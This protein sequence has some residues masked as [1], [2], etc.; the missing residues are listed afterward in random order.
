MAG[1]GKSTISRT[2]AQSLA[3]KEVL[4]ASF[5]FK[6]GEGDRG[7]TSRFFTTIAAQLA[8]ELP[9]LVP[10][11][12]AALEANPSL[13]EKSMEQQFNKLLLDPLSVIWQ[14]SLAARKKVIVLIDALDECEEE[15]HI[16]TILSLLSRFR[17]I[18]GIDLRIFVTSRPELPIRLG[19]KKIN[20]DAH[21]DVAL[22]DIPERIVDHDLRAVLASELDMLREEHSLHPPWPTRD[23]LD[24]LV[25]ITRP[26][27]IHA[28]TVCR[29]ISDELL[30][31]PRDLLKNILKFRGNSSTS[32]LSATYHPVLHQ[33]V[34][35][36]QNYSREMILRRFR[37]IVGTIIALFN[38][39]PK[40]ALVALLD[41]STSHV[42][43]VLNRLHSVLRVPSTE[44][45][46]IQLF[47]LSFHDFLVDCDQCDTDFWIDEEA[48]HSRIA[49]RCIQIMSAKEGLREDI[50]GL[51]HPGKLR[52]EVSS[53]TV[54]TC[55]PAVLQYACRHWVDHLQRSGRTIRD[56]EETDNFLRKHF[57]HF[58]E[59]LGLLGR[60]SESILMIATLQSLLSV[61]QNY[62]VIQFHYL[63]TSRTTG[64]HSVPYF[65]KML[66][67]FY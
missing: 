32:D 10:H 16:Q 50:C 55:L 43:G 39:L 64:A 33:L 6:R 11:I 37:L 5:F 63:T 29:Y 18:K 46:P 2:V 34:A 62:H 14:K 45:L 7:N 24:A 12:V 40:P 47:H 8:I 1:T 44:A 38:P 23:E 13:P 59:A 42:E 65:S 19:F 67:A 17:S 57:L 28:A 61:G 31:N 20:S 30:G 26:L 60:I 21:K 66:S 53:R 15:R 56:N 35:N 52:S 51:E 49:M 9:E 48:A 58:L 3:V 25:T 54:D 41:M 27:F 22:H 36:R 4:S